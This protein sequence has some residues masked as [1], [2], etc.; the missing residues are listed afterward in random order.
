ME[1][2][3][4]LIVSI[5]VPFVTGLLVRRSYPKIVKA[6]IAF[7]LAAAVGAFVTY[8]AGGFQGDIWTA[9][10]ACYGAGQVTFW[11]VVERAGIKDWLLS[12]FNADA[13]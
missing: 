13:A 3:I 8:Q 6:L 9:I 4:G 10:M 7:V 2:V 11:L 1:E 12:H 5:L